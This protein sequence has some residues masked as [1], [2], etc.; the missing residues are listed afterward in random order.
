[1]ARSIVAA[2]G[3]PALI[4]TLGNPFD[5]VRA[6]DRAAGELAGAQP[7]SDEAWAVLAAVERECEAARAIADAPA[8]V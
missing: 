1:M 6:Y 5:F 8:G 7:F 3:L 2:E 4:A